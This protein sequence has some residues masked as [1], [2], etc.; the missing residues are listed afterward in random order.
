MP[1]LSLAERCIY[2]PVTDI[3]H[4]PMCSLES[5]KIDLKGLGE[6]VKAYDF[7]LGDSFFAS[8]D[9]AEVSRGSVDLK[10]T[11][12]KPLER[13]YELDFSVSGVVIVPCDRCLDDMEQPIENTGHL[14]VKLGKEYSEDDD[15]I[16]IDENDGTL[17]IT[18][19][20]YEYIAL[21]IPMK[22]THAD[23]E[24]NASMMELLEAHTVQ[25]QDDEEPEIDPRW[26]QLKKIR[27]NI[28]E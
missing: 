28:K 1:S 4:E 21:A 10:L 7:K 11:V 22:H 9:D 2:L 5:L 3:S 6:D 12:R 20:V 15:L 18:W 17:D 19:F 26:E 27:N 23:G 25:A 24:C 13:C 8:I 16:T 14:V